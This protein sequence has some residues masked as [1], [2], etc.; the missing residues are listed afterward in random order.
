MF[1]GLRTTPKDEYGF[2]NINDAGVPV[3]IPPFTARFS[4][5][6]LG[7][8][9]LL[10]G[11]EDGIISILDTNRSLTDQMHASSP[12]QAPRARFRGHDNAIFDAI[13]LANDTRVASASG[14]ATVRVFDP[15]T[16]TRTALC[17]GATGTVRCVREVPSSNGSLLASC[18]RDGAI[19]VHDVRVQSV[20]DPTIF[21]EAFHKPVL[22]LHNA[23]AAPVA[24]HTSA[25][26]RR[27]V[28]A[29]QPMSASVTSMVF[30]PGREYELFSGGSADGCV[31]LWDLRTGGRPRPGTKREA[32]VV[33]CVTPSAEQRGNATFEN[34]RRHGIVSLDLDASGSKLLA[35]ST[36]STIYLYDAHQISLGHSRTLRGHTATSFYIRS[37]FSPCGR[38]VAAGS[39]DSK[40]YLWDVEQDADGDDGIQPILQL[41]GHRGGEVSVVEWC[42][43]DMFKLVTCG[44]DTT[45]KLWQVEYGLSAERPWVDGDVPGGVARTVEVPH[46]SRKKKQSICGG[47]LQG[48]LTG[49]GGC[50]MRRLRDSDIRQFFGSRSS[51]SSS[52]M[53]DGSGSNRKIDHNVS[54]S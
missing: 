10:A 48:K 52:Q 7:G 16:Q 3:A 31:K 2:W 54:S 18:G 34:R 11:D 46:L 4:T 27:R 51:S 12:S 25:T 45:A 37:S 20:Y 36:D 23:H 14:D 5:T 15:D 32:Q 38:F 8:H 26:K 29:A 19:R 6:V 49:R 47:S 24:V 9:A 33:D 22:T 43:A 53:K 30:M 28:F 17:R 1:G 42:K 50:S 41:D 35:S 44:D 40:A 13:W 39:A 21:S